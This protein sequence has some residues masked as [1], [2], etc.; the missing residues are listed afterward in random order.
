VVLV[1]I[2]N[3]SVLDGWHAGWGVGPRYMIPALPF[4]AVGLAEAFARW[5]RISAALALVSILFM[6]TFTV[7]DAQS[8]VGTSPIADRPDRSGVWREPWSEY[9]VPIFLTGRATPIL[10]ARAGADGASPGVEA[11]AFFQGPVSAH[12]IGVYEA[13]IGRVFAPPARELAWNAFN[14]GELL[15]PESRLTPLLLV[16]LVTPLLVG[17]WRIARDVDSGG[18]CPEGGIDGPRGESG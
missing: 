12:P 7:V 14:L 15:L 9:A 6:T 10:D 4:L 5:P 18:P 17:A 16:V 1:W 11:L 2:T 3:A 8:P 13:W